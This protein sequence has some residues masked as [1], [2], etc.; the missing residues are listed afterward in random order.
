MRARLVIGGVLLAAAGAL[1]I[2]A[3][4]AP[5]PS[6][7]TLP[8]ACVVVNGPSGATLQIGYA[9]TGPSGCTQLP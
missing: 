6:A 8:A 7:T 2:P 1:A 4:A 9:P 3:F 5:A